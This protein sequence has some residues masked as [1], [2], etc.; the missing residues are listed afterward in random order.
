M[1]SPTHAL[2]R[3]LVTVLTEYV[4]RD[5]GH[6]IL[7]VP[8]DPPDVLPHPAASYDGAVAWSSP[9]EILDEIARVLVPGGR[10]LVGTDEDLDALRR[11]LE[12]AGFEVTARSWR[13]PAYGA[14]LARLEERAS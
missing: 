14:L 12:A 4:R 6:R 8:S 1:S 7:D 2:D 10:L 9:T 5:G 3:A 11:D 13:E